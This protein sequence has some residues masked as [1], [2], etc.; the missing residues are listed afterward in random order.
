MHRLLLP[1][2]FATTLGCA[3]ASSAG[4]ELPAT[5]AASATTA[6]STATAPQG[7]VR[8]IDVATLKA[9]LDSGAVPLLVDVRTPGE[10]AGGHVPGAV[11]IPLDQ[12]D[13][14]LSEFGPTDRDLYLVC[15]SGN[16][17]GS[18]ARALAAQGYQPINV[19]GGTSAWAGAGLAVDR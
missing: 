6:A 16:R 8:T 19:A 13:A 9:D 5:S 4:T 12:L 18:A 14:R 10:F 1:L 7:Q 3:S 2:L 15:Q 11:N 17:S